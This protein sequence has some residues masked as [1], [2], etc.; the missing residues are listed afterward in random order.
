MTHFVEQDRMV[1][2][3][4][5]LK[6]SKLRGVLSEAMVFAAS[7]SDHTQVE[8]VDPPT[9]TKIGEKVTFDGF[10]GEPD[11][12]LHP[13]HKVWEAVQPVRYCFFVVWNFFVL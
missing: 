3:L 7:N 6:P 9:G 13:K 1:V 12:G 11:T 2:L 8:L 4:C 5:N 10:Q